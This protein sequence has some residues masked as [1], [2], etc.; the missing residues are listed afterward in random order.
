[1]RSL[2][3]CWFFV[4]LLLGLGGC[5]YDA[6]VKGDHTSEQYKVDLEKCRASSAES[7]RLKNADTFGTWII[8]P[9]TGPPAVRAAIRKCMTGKG[10]VLTGG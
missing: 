10:Y 8:S 9:F 5:A 6:S 4:G 3:T 1:M 7:V 2:G